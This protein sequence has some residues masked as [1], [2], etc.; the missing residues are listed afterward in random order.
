M[1]E[2]TDAASAEPPV[3]KEPD[4]EMAADLT[5]RA[6]YKDEHSFLPVVN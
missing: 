1:A 6:S 4:D 5:G 2:R 3:I